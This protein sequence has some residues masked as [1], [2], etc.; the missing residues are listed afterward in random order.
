MS[1]YANYLKYATILPIY[2]NDISATGHV[3]HFVLDFR[4]LL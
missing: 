3:V 2:N 4:C 1:N